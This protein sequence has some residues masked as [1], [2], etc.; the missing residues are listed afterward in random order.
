MPVDQ[1]ATQNGWG[2]TTVINLGIHQWTMV[3]IGNA[4]SVS[5]IRNQIDCRKPWR[6]DMI[7]NGPTLSHVISLCSR[8]PVPLFSSLGFGGMLLIEEERF[9]TEFGGFIANAD[10]NAILVPNSEGNG[11][12]MVES[13]V[14]G[15]M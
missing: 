3:G 13:A 6:D 2:T 10:A 15:Q 9:D 1:Y 14:D 5:P 11:L 7:Q 8:V 4:S 12:Q